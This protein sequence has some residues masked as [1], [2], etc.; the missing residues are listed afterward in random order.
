[1]KLI[2]L[3]VVLAVIALDFSGCSSDSAAQNIA[4][5]A[6]FV[7]IYSGIMTSTNVGQS[8]L[9]KVLSTQDEFADAYAAY[10]GTAAPVL[11]FNI[12]KVLLLDM[13]SRATGGYSTALVSVDVG[14]NAVVANAD[15]VKPGPNCM[16][17]QALTHPFQFAFIPTRMEVLLSERI[18]VTNCM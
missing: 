11:D 9:A 12:G 2:S 6:Q 14:T 13:G 1:M 10:V 18:T 5:E 7:P 8:K 16:V 15:L 3:I 17:T 4:P